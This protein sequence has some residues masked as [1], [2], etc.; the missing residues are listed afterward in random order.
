MPPRGPPSGQK[1]QRLENGGRSPPPPTG[2][3]RQ[4]RPSVVV[5]SDASP[6]DDDELTRLDIDADFKASLRQMSPRSRRE[7]VN[8]I[9]RNQQFARAEQM[10]A[11]QNEELVM[12]R[13]LEEDN[14]EDDGSDG[15]PSDDDDDED[16]DDVRV[17][18]RRRGH[19]PRD[20]GDFFA[21]LLMHV[22]AQQGGRGGRA[23]GGRGARG[24]GGMPPAFAQ[25]NPL[26]QHLQQLL[27]Q[28]EMGLERDIDAM[29]YEELLEL[30]DRIGYVSKGL[31]PQEIASST[32]RC[33]VTSL[34]KSD[35]DESCVI[36]QS[37]LG[38]DNGDDDDDDVRNVPVC[39]QVKRCGH[40][41]HQE[42]LEQWL[43]A[44]KSC[45]LCKSDVL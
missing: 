31:R 6:E 28:R 23:R 27:S 16:N 22:F 39:L 35:A 18:P 13:R 14:G 38:G 5:V 40:K 26:L 1:R 17:A 4:A 10:A 9:V 42:C 45:P 37:G 21:E 25:I 36:C 12:R 32:Q 11:Q 33:D 29:S 20:E 24:R 7:I 44:N 3:P 8:D 2:A 34:A 19:P 15:S 30:Q 43:R 41:F